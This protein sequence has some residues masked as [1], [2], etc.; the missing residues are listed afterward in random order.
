[1][2][3]IQVGSVVGCHRARWRRGLVHYSADASEVASWPGP[4][5]A[6]G[7]LLVVFERKANHSGRR[8][9]VT[10]NHAVQRVDEAE[11]QNMLAR[12][13]EGLKAKGI[14]FDWQEEEKD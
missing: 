2:G 4:E 8:N 1:M 12:T 9:V 13:I 7:D 5:E 6:G 3:T 10:G 11:F 14:E